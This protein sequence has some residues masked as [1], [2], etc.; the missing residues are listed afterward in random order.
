MTPDPSVHARHQQERLSVYPAHILIEIRQHQPGQLQAA[1]IDHESAHR[2][3]RVRTRVMSL[4]MTRTHPPPRNR[5][6]E[7]HRPQPIQ[8]EL[9]LRAIVIPDP[10]HRIRR[11]HPDTTLCHHE[12]DSKDQVR[13]HCSPNPDLAHPVLMTIRNCSP[14]RG[15]YTVRTRHAAAT[16]L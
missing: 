9:P 7:V 13:S 2:G 8:P 10:R 11:P 15:P 6:T 5:I 12:T 3:R 4:A 16:Q 14:I 1:L